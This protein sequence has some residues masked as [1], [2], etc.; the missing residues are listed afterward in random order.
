VEEKS[1]AI[2]R[3]IPEELYQQIGSYLQR[4]PWVDVEGF[5]VEY[6]RLSKLVSTKNDDNEKDS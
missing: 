1:K 5:M 3:V 4:C 6:L 2:G